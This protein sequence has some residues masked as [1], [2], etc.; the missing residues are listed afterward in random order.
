MLAEVD[1]RSRNGE[2]FAL[3]AW[4]PYWMNQRY[5]LKFL[6][7]PEDAFGEVNDPARITTIVNE[8]LPQDD[9]EATEFMDALVLDKEQGGDLESAINEAANP[10]EGAKR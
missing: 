1:Q 10:Y 4:S 3:A 5:G 9:P 2:E 8:D 6:E 7:N